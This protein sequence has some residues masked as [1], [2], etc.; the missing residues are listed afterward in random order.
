M[1]SS[2]SSLSGTFGSSSSS[3]RRG[4]GRG[5]EQARHDLLGR[6]ELHELVLE[7]LREAPVPEVPRVELLQ[8]A[9]RAPLAE[10]AHGLADEVDQLGGDL[11]AR[12]LRAVAVDDLADRPRVALRAAADHHRCRA[13]RGE[14]GF[15]LRARRHVARRDHRHV[16]EL[17]ELRRQRVIR[18]ARVHLL[19]RARVQRQRRGAGLDEPRPELERAARAVVDAAPHLHAHRHVDRVRDG[20]G[21]PARERLVLEQVRA[22]AGL[23]HLADGAAEVHVDDVRAGGHDHPRRLCHRARVG[24]E[25]LDRERMLVGGHPQVAERLL[26]P[27]LDPGAGDHLRADEAGPVA[28]ALAPERLHRDARHGCEDDPRG[29]LDVPDPPRFPKIYLH[30]GIVPG[31]C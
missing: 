6:R 19:R 27:V 24:A 22:R 10:L 16:D 8:E 5:R 29:D 12:R 18:V 23:R 26:V 25:D 9:G 20:L 14:N 1:P 11:L 21:D 17:D 7:R 3:E 15:R 2:R 4:A 30:A 31:H 28:A 13:R